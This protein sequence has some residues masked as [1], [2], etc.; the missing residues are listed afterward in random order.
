MKLKM[1]L[2]IFLLAAT[3]A[4]SSDKSTHHGDHRN[5]LLKFHLIDGDASSNLEGEARVLAFL[6]RNHAAYGLNSAVDNLELIEV[7]ESLLGTHYRYQQMLRGHKVDGGSMIVSISHEDGR[8]YQ[9]YNNTYP[10]A[11]AKKINS[12]AR[13]DKEDAFDIAWLDM[14]VH[15]KLISQPKAE[16]IFQPVGRDFRLVYRTEMGVEAPFGYW[17]HTIDASSGEI[18]DVRSAAITRE[19]V[20]ADFDSYKGPVLDRASSFADYAAE[21]RARQ[22]SRK[23]ALVANGTG[24]VFD[25]DPVTTLADDT[26]EDGSPASAFTGA[27]FTRTL[28]DIDL[29]GSTYSLVGPWVQI[30]NFE[31]PNTAPSTTT[32][33]NWTATR[34]NNSFNDAIT[35]FQLDQ[36]QRYMQSLG[37]TGATGIQ[38]VSI[39]ADTDGY[40]GSDNSHYFPGSNRLGFGHGCVDDNEDT[41]V[42]LHEYGHAITYGINSS[43]GGGDSGAMGEGFGDYWGGAYRWSTPNGNFHPEWAFPWDGHNNCWGGRVMNNTG[44]YNPG[45]TYGAH[46]TVNGVNGDELWSSPLFQSLVRLTNMGVPQGEVDQIV[47]EAMFNVGNGPSMRDMATAVVAAANALQPTGPH[48]GIFTEEF[49]LRNILANTTPTQTTSNFSGKA[50]KKAKNHNI[51]VVDGNIDL[52][53]SWSASGDLDLF[54]YNPS[55]SLVASSAGSSNPET[56]T[57]NTGGVTGTYQIRVIKNGSGRGINYNLSATYY[58]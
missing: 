4:Q 34:G 55:G 33:G 11:F 43:W 16:L 1:A 35:Y 18:L 8:I 36:S 13:L 40:G 29:N 22:V 39:E 20:T 48:A 23:A 58:Q 54:L 3:W 32:T 51:T 17:N 28:Q 41:F 26:L 15:G 6:E 5:G 53:L 56:I 25:P 14:R 31:S 12:A 2:A 47:L 50:G 57:Y 19:L 52:S 49:E 38:D 37:F 45:S 24:V 21:S 7:R 46:T 9:A 42:I 10:V 44:Q 30:V 27:Y